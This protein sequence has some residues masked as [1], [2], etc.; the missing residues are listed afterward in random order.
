VD[1]STFREKMIRNYG[2][3]YNNLT[4]NH[5]IYAWLRVNEDNKTV[6]IYR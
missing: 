3:M 4:P 1:V 6:S 2:S 5:H